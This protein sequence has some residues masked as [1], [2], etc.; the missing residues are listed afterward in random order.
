MIETNIQWGDWHRST[1]DEKNKWKQVIDVKGGICEIE[2]CRTDS[3]GLYQFK[4]PSRVGIVDPTNGQTMY[5]YKITQASFPD[6][7][8]DVNSI[9][10]IEPIK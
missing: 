2:Q 7:K 1:P 3:N 9:L 5:S 10:P 8:L 4:E 6:G